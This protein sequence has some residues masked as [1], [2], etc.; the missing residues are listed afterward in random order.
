MDCR[1]RV[2]VC[3]LVAALLACSS[4]G[5]SGSPPESGDPGASQ[6]TAASPTD[7]GPDAGSAGPGGCATPLLPAEPVELADLSGRWAQVQIAA[8]LASIPGIGVSED[9]TLTLLLS[10]HVQD[11]EEVT[12]TNKICGFR[13]ESQ[14]SLVTTLFPDKFVDSLEDVTRAVTYRKDESGHYRYEAGRVWEARGI[15]LGSLESDELPESADD[16]R[17]WDQ[18]VDGKPGMTILV[19]GGINGELQLIQRNWTE[20]SGWPT[21]ADR[22]EGRQ[23]FHTD[24][25]FI[26]SDPQ[27][28]KALAPEASADPDP[29]KSSFHM[30]RVADDADCEWLLEHEKE[31]LPG[32]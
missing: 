4:N 6:D 22:I 7:A 31:L 25:V 24:Q 11:G 21:A 14:V 32:M 29:C 28:L 9:R 1:L 19:S 18:D 15:K 16:E 5:D 23:P 3:V 26:G 8:S 17:V 12:V 13:M 20:L 10:D 30:V 27:A 2:I